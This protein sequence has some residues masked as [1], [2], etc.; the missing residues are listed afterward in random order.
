MLWIPPRGKQAPL[1]HVAHWPEVMSNGS[2]AN[3]R[4]NAWS[5]QRAGGEFEG[6]VMLH[7]GALSKVRRDGGH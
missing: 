5:E 2:L 4:W 6:R 1:E 7:M 3:S